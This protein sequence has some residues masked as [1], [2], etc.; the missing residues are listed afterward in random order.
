MTNVEIGLDDQLLAG[1]RPKFYRHGQ[2]TGPPATILTAGWLHSS[3]PAAIL[4][5]TDSMSCGN[6]TA[7]SCI[8]P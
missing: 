8:S 2:L 4:H 7:A 1:Y 5:T 3:N 6:R